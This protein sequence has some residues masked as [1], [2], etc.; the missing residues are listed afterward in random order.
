MKNMFKNF[1]GNS[2]EIR[3]QYCYAGLNVALLHKYI[4][5]KIAIRILITINTHFSILF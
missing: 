1:S 3:V 4:L 2:Q 5:Y